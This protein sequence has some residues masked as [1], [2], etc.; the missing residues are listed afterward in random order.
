MFQHTTINNFEEHVIVTFVNEFWEYLIAKIMDN[1]L[2]DEA[3][4]AAIRNKEKELK[5][6]FMLEY[7][8]YIKL[9]FLP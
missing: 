9:H 2:F 6:D 5:S 3:D 4:K 8:D 1:P 7:S